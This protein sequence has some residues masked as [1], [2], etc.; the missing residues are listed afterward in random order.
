M[1]IKAQ[2]NLAFYYYK[3][4][5]SKNLEQI[6]Y[7]L[8]KM[9]KEKDV[10]QQ[11][12]SVISDSDLIFSITPAQQKYN[13][14]DITNTFDINFIDEIQ[15]DQLKQKSRSLFDDDCKIKIDDYIDGAQN[16]RALFNTTENYLKS[17]SDS[18]ISSPK[19][20]EYKQKENKC[21]YNVNPENKQMLQNNI[22]QI[23]NGKKQSKTIIQEQLDTNQREITV[24]NDPN[25]KDQSFFDNLD[26]SINLN[27]TKEQQLP[28]NLGEGL[29]NHTQ[30]LFKNDQN[31]DNQFNNQ[32]GQLLQKQNL[33]FQ[34]LF[35]KRHS[36]YNFQNNQNEQS[37]IRITQSHQFDHL[38]NLTGSQKFYAECK[39]IPNFYS[40]FKRNPLYMNSKFMQED[41]AKS[42][43][44]QKALQRSGSTDKGRINGDEVTIDQKH[45]ISKEP[46]SANLQ[47]IDNTNKSNAINSKAYKS[48][49]LL[50]LTNRFIDLLK[51][52][53]RAILFK[54]L[55]PNHFR[56]I[57]DKSYV[58]IKDTFRYNDEI[59]NYN[60][61]KSYSGF[62]FLNF[63]QKNKQDKFNEKDH[64]I[65][66]TEN[67]Y[68]KGLQQQLIH[69]GMLINKLP[70][71]AP[72]N[73]L[74]LIW[75]LIMLISIVILLFYIPI[76][77]S[78]KIIQN[79]LIQNIGIML[80]VIDI[81]IKSNTGFFRDGQIILQRTKILIEIFSFQ[82]WFSLIS[83][84]SLLQSNQNG[85]QLLFL[86]NVLSILKL[87]EK[88]DYHFQ[89]KQKYFIQFEI[90]KL[91][92]IILFLSSSL[93]SIFYFIS[94]R[95]VENGEKHAWIL[96][97]PI[98]TWYDG[99]IFS[100]YF[101]FITMSTV[102]YG[103]LTPQ[104]QAEVI[105]VGFTSI[106][107]SFFFA[108]CINS[109]GN[110]LTDI[111]QREQNYK[112]RKKDVLQYLNSRGISRNLQTKVMRH[113]EYLQNIENSQSHIN[114]QDIMKYFSDNLRFEINKEF[115]GKQLIDSK[116][117]GLH[118]THPFLNTLAQSMK[119]ITLAPGEILYQKNQNDNRILFLTSG[120]LE[121]FEKEVQLRIV[122][123]GE[124]LNYRGFFGNYSHSSSARSLTISHLSYC[125]QEDIIQ[126]LKTFPQD[127]ESFCFIRD[128]MK[129]QNKTIDSKCCSCQS[130]SHV[131]QECPLILYKINKDIVIKRWN[132]SNHNERQEFQ[133]KKNKFKSFTNIQS[134]KNK[135]KLYKVNLISNLEEYS[136]LQGNELI[137][138]LEDKEFYQNLPSV[139]IS[140]DGMIYQQ[141]DHTNTDSDMSEDEEQVQDQLQQSLQQQ[142]QQILQNNQIVNQSSLLQSPQTKQFSKNV[143]QLSNQMNQTS[144]LKQDEEILTDT[145]KK[146][147]FQQSLD[148]QMK[149]SCITFNKNQ[150]INQN[151]ANAQNNQQSNL[152]NQIEGSQLENQKNQREESYYYVNKNLIYSELEQQ[153]QEGIILQKQ[154]EQGNNKNETNNNFRLLDN[155][156]QKQE[157]IP[158]N[159]NPNPLSSFQKQNSSN[160]SNNQSMVK[161]Q[162]NYGQQQTLQQQQPYQL[163]QQN[164]L[165]ISQNGYSIKPSKK[166]YKIQF[167]KINSSELS[168]KQKQQKYV[169][170]NQVNNLNNKNQI[171]QQCK[172]QMIASNQVTTTHL[173]T[174]NSK[175]SKGNSQKVNK[176]LQEQHNQIIDQQE[177]LQKHSSIISERKDKNGQEK[178]GNDQIFQFDFDQ[179]KE[180]SNYYPQNNFKIV[181]KS[182]QQ[183][184]KNLSRIA[185]LNKKAGKKRISK[186]VNQKMTKLNFDTPKM[187][188]M[189]QIK[190]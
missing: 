171:C 156:F 133:R 113:L 118:F 9:I 117:F 111:A 186:P 172:N 189:K 155:I 134:V 47:K 188:A 180:Y 4:T 53:S 162:A 81:I 177:F 165:N 77:C 166:N 32:E 100:I 68:L 160:S 114:S 92:F 3:I 190:D 158:I 23:Q 109:I 51:K 185:R 153:N 95:Q 34:K 30:S 63:S 91:I 135:L 50:H 106:S 147:T 45:R 121:L 182:L 164:T 25:L 29:N 152:I 56:I 57:N 126:V 48:I 64:V 40:S 127:Y 7:I 54:R 11:N 131:F 69:M 108:Y 107:F 79:S 90:F 140:E 84:F 35:K 157:S 103:D 82:L 17:R 159:Y 130:Y 66:I 33:N 93:G 137:E 112:Q 174:T 122:K 150:D 21:F 2:F 136:Y 55:K 181:I 102:G 124:I 74:L 10:N 101:M 176:I 105:F 71:I 37:S 49:Q 187:S 59:Q 61:K 16:R 151:Q 73:S 142:Q 128:E 96:T 46:C 86:I 28:E 43:F 97:K 13:I 39:N 24:Q 110:M 148:Q 80:I 83:I 22:Y 116:V 6:I 5:Y 184:M 15:E 173:S 144:A 149:S 19:M 18:E 75:N 123:K 94:E 120:D 119:E 12:V 169:I 141:S 99:Y 183:C 14:N 115:F 138:Y 88:L 38:S 163:S 170:Q 20:F 129:L 8:Q 132:Y 41:A 145:D 27:N 76:Q 104:N 62:N 65:N 87:I 89:F 85:L 146:F 58:Q 139:K 154:S 179:M 52:N 167:C 72:D 42:S 161:N 26:L 67:I 178:V 36:D 125:T 143:S 168:E 175:Q 70:I 60:F 31:D 98:Q 44:T 1:I 78:F